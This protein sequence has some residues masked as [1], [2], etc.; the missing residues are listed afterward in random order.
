MHYSEAF[1]W[2]LLGI[3]IAIGFR[4]FVEWMTYI[5]NRD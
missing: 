5:N 1:L 3:C 4:Y 2:T